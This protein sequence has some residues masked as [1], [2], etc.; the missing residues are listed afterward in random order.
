MDAKP[1][2]L[3]AYSGGLDTSCI[4]RWLVEEGYEVL[5]FIADVGQEADFK[6]AEAKALKV[7]A[8][9]VFVVDLRKEFVEEFVFPC[10]Q[11]N[12]L[13]GG[14]YLLGTSMARPCIARAQ[15]Q[16]AARENCQFVSHG[17]TGKG[18]DQ[19][20]FELTYYAF[21]PTIKVIA[22]WR[23]PS[24]LARFKGRPDLV[25]YAIQQ[26]IPLKAT[27]S[28]LPYSEDDNL[29][30]ISHESGVLEDP[31]F[32]TPE[33]VYS[34]TTAPEKAPSVPENITI[35]FKNGV[36]VRVKNLDD[37]TEKSDPLELFLYLNTLGSKHGIGRLD[38]VEDRFVGIKSRGVYETPGGTILRNAHLDMESITQDREVNRLAAQ[39]STKFAELIYNGFWF[40]PEF[41]LLLTLVK[42]SQEDVTG[43]VQLSLYRG[44]AYPVARSSPFSRYDKDLVSFD[45]EGGFNPVDSEGF[46]RI[47]AI[48]LK[49]NNMLQRKRESAAV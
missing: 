1:R 30:H 27:A 4:L 28:E 16:I 13:Y 12:A 5:A 36:P 42:K 19:V 32:V 18:N 9:K 2:V 35:D 11:A 3:L 38:M 47:N 23:T 40:S 39:F 37:G 31:A 29:F 26:G 14:R 44:V 7:G 45:H 15:V 10:I 17:C 34:L 46:I 25:Q 20:R 21:E 49:V 8:S 22:P 24:F 33:S 43:S 41:D 6:A 48:R